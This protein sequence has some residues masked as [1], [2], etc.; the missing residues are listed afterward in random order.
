[1]RSDEPKSKGVIKK[2]NLRELVRTPHLVKRALKSYQ[3]LADEV[4]I[5]KFQQG[6]LVAFDVIV[7][8]YKEQLI[9]YVYT[10]VGD[11][12]DAEDI[13]QDT[14]VKIYRF[15][16]SYKNIAKFSTWIYTVAG[17]LA[18]SELRKR[19]RQ[20]LYPISSLNNGD[21]E[22]EAVETRINSDEMTDSAVKKELIKKAIRTLPDHYQLVIRMREIDNMS[23]EEIAEVTRLPLGTVR[24][25]I[26]RARIRLQNKLK[27]LVEK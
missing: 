19:K 22:F 9:N 13:V 26:S 18:K 8:R 7:A 27:Y 16:Q 11:K 6:D 17:N 4:V 3:K 20:Q 5:K 15:R 2:E 23:Y 21:K 1:M 24:S 25:R 12:S 10:F 14:F